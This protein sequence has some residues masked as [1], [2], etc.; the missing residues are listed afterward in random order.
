MLQPVEGAPVRLRMFA[1]ARKINRRGC[2]N[3]SLITIESSRARR[4][5]AATVLP[6]LPR[7][8]HERNFGP[9]S[10]PQKALENDAFSRA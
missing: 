8:F 9:N 5:Y 7:R 4:L 3:G 6:P 2:D 1:E 10:E